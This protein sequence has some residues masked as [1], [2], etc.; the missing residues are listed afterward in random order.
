MWCAR[1]TVRAMVADSGRLR[2][3]TARPGP[4]AWRLSARVV[5]DDEPIVA[6][7]RDLRA[8]RRSQQLGPQ[9]VLVDP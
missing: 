7:D 2:D 9:S 4:V 8:G 3:L 5:L 1:D 6:D